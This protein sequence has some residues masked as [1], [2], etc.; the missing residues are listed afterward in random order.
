MDCEEHDSID[1]DAGTSLRLLREDVDVYVRSPTD[2]SGRRMETRSSHAGIDMRELPGDVQLKLENDNDAAIYNEDVCSQK[3]PPC[4][5]NSVNNERGFVFKINKDLDTLLHLSIIHDLDLS[6]IVFLLY[7]WVERPLKDFVTYV[8]YQNRMHQSALHIATLVRR[9]DVIRL[10]V[11]IGGKT[12]LRDNKLRTAMHIA[13]ENGDKELLCAFF[14]NRKICS[15]GT[16]LDLHDDTGRTCLHICV[17][18]GNIAMT[19]ILLKYGANINVTERTNGRTALYLA[20]ETGN[21]EMVCF[22]LQFMPEMQNIALLE[23]SMKEHICLLR[24][25][26]LANGCDPLEPNVLSYSQLSPLDIANIRS[27]LP[28][29]DLLSVVCTAEHSSSDEE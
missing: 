26:R 6:A 12:C 25:L 24:L 19:S 1:V 2:V 18:N 10:L 22:L 3:S 21:V 5:D 7:Q 20:A 8:N 16:D 28:V 9:C 4:T 11:D 27:H 29:T 13:C 23:E 15:G 17:A 14:M